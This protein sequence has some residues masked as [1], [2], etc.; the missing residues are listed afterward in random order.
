M[1]RR[2]VTVR[3]RCCSPPVSAVTTW[4]VSLWTFQ[5]RMHWSPIWAKGLT[6]PRLRISTGHVGRVKARSLIRVAGP[7]GRGG[8]GIVGVLKPTPP[9]S[10]DA[11][12]RP[13]SFPALLVTPVPIPGT[14]IQEGGHGRKW[15]AHG[16]PGR[17]AGGNENKGIAYVCL[18]FSAVN[19]QSF[20]RFSKGPRTPN[21]DCLELY[22]FL[23]EGFPDEA[24]PHEVPPLGTDGLRSSPLG[25]GPSTFAFPVPE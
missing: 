25:P 24:F 3:G 8:R 9:H 10:Q 18:C 7:R 19:V 1:C 13:Q 2:S 11:E 20:N 23:Q 4:T 6:A 5:T 22:L 12:I 14:F 16:L 21:T 17:G 15:D